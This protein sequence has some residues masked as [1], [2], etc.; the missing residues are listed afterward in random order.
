MQL[1]LEK[2]FCFFLGGPARAPHNCFFWV[3]PPGLPMKWPQAVKKFIFIFI[4]YLG[5]N[6]IYIQLV[7]IE[8]HLA[9]SGQVDRNNRTGDRAAAAIAQVTWPLP[10]HN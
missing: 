7:H 5:L 9:S 4:L 1:Q 8:S 3:G 10:V 2:F 6:G